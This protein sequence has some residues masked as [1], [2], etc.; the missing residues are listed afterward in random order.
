MLDV[1]LKNQLNQLNLRLNI[2]IYFLGFKI[3][4]G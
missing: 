2:L 1:L 3:F 4:Y